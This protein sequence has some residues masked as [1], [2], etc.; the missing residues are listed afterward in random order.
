MIQDLNSF[1]LAQEE[2]NRSC[3]LALRS[4]ILNLDSQLSETRKYGVPCFCYGKK[5]LCYLWTDKKTLEPYLLMVEGQ[6]LKHPELE[7]GNRSR[8]KI[9]R[10]NPN[11]D[12]PVDSLQNLLLE[13]LGLYR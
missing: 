13:A 5:A 11:T 12:L 4:F 6:R 2:P 8:M 9:F 7:Q 10:V 3:L 1:Y